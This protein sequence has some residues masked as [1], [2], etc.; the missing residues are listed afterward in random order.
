MNTR[1][2][3]SRKVSAANIERVKA[4]WNLAETTQE[5]FATELGIVVSTFRNFLDGKPVDK[6]IFGEICFRLDLDPIE[7]S[8]PISELPS[9]DESPFI[10]GNPITEPRYFFGHER[11]LQRIFHILNRSPLQNVAIIGEKH[12]GK[13]SFLH[14][15]KNITT[16]STD[17]LRN[18]QKQDWLTAPTHYRWVFVDFQNPNLRSESGLLQHILDS[19]Q[20]PLPPICD[21]NSFMRVMPQYLRQPTVILF[22]EIAR[23]LQDCPELDDRFWESLRSLACNYANQN[24]AYIL[25]TPIFP[26]DLAKN[27]GCSSPFF[28]IFGYTANLGAFTPTEAKELIANAPQPFTVT[29]VEW[30]LEQSRC[31][32][33][34]LQILCRECWLSLELGEDEDWR[35][36]ALEQIAPFL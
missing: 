25:A 30:I 4:R 24:L 27:Y 6:K 16:T 12:M 20:I 15:L 21:I 23:V 28:N 31:L 14:Y 29:D 19:L 26:Y 32:P 7:I 22:D 34:L 17:L 2:P 10:T 8:Q 33:L 18:G 13:T 5:N 36:S 35:T 3:R 1:S 11:Q 9:G